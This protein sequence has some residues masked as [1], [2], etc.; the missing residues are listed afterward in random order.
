MKTTQSYDAII[1]G[2]SFAG[3]A[4]ALQ[5]VR[6]RRQVLVI[7]A[8]LRRNRFAHA[9]HGFLGQD[10]RPPAAIIQD[11]RTQLEAYPTL[12]IVNGS[13]E[14]AQQADSGFEI[15]LTDSTR[16]SAS[17]LILAT[18]VVDQLPDIAGLQERWGVTVAHCP[19]CHGYEVAGKRLGVLA[20]HPRFFHSAKLIQEWG[21]I[22]LFTNGQFTLEPG[23]EQA[24]LAGGMIIETSP[25]T[26]LEGPGQS[27]AGVRLADGRLVEIDTLFVASKTHQSSPL[28][29]QLGCTFDEGF[30]GPIVRVDAFQQTTVQGVYAAGDAARAATNI[31]FAV[32]DGTWAGISV[33]QSLID[34]EPAH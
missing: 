30:S 32:S 13:A 8:G 28:A 22:T 7:D 24:L 16:Y 33:H 23:Q 26:S 6:A 4:A 34:F 18:G 20:S 2:G 1:V 3:L 12:T 5:L 15:T 17:R 27:L 11:A 10:R 29:A 9:A 31:T 21:P 25:V 14:H 19:Y